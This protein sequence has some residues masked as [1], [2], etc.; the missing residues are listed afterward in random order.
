MQDIGKEI[1]RRLMLAFTDAQ[2]LIQ[3]VSDHH[4]NHPQSPG[5]GNSHFTLHV[6][7]PDF[8]GLSRIDRQRKIYHLLDD[9]MDNPIHMLSIKAED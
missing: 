4:K 6:K 1:E 5:T 7:T 9:L 8:K 3:D 2:V